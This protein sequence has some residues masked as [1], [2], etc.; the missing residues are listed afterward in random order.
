MRDIPKTESKLNSVLF[1]GSGAR[2]AAGTAYKWP[3]VSARNGLGSIL[4]F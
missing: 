4:S 3:Q 2:R 1:A